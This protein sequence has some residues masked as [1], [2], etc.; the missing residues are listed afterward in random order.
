MLPRYSELMRGVSYVSLRPP[1]GAM[2]FE[3]YVIIM[4]KVGKALG[5]GQKV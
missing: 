5:I 3:T 4:G 1:G 2:D